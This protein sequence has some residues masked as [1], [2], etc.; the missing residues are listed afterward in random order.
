MGTDRDIAI[1]TAANMATD[2]HYVWLNVTECD[3]VNYLLQLLNGKQSKGD[4]SNV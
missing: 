2:E 4:L 3:N 1:L